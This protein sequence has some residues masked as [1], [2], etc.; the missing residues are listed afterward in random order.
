MKVLGVDTGLAISGYA[1]I[2]YD[3]KQKVRDIIDYGIVETHKATPTSE[4]LFEI[5]KAFQSLIK[6]H[7]PDYLAIEELFFFKNQKTFVRVLESRGVV[8]VVGEK[9][10]V[11]ICEYTPLQIKQCLTGYGRASKSQIQE[12]VKVQL[13][14]KSIPKPDDAADALAICLTHIQ[15]VRYK[16]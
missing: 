6:T 13:G 5:F 10:K 3:D 14:L 11:Q 7:K 16:I 9:N 2:E 4:R 12:M 1:I 15:T 8:L